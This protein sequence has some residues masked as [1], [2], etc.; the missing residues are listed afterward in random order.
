MRG[1]AAERKLGLLT[2]LLYQNRVIATGSQIE[3]EG[4]AINPGEVPILLNAGNVE[5]K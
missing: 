2:G 4:E 1:I 5:R 3:P